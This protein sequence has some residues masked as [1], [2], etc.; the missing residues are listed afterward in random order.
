M[1]GR[2]LE[3]LALHCDALIPSGLPSNTE[4]A[5][6]DPNWKAAIDR[7][8]NSLD[9][10]GVWELVKPPS[11]QGFISGKWHFAHKL[12]DEGNVV[13]YKGRFVAGGSLRRHALIFTTPTRQRRSCLHS[14]L[15]WHVGWSWVCISIRWT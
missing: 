3:N 11:E 12:D 10:N 6:A 5:L 7:E 13:K 14:D 9:E 15:S 4:D 2:E 8:F 1:T